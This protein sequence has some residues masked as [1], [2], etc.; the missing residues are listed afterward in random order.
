MRWEL[1]GIVLFF[2]LVFGLH[3]LFLLE[4]KPAPTLL[5]HIGASLLKFRGL[6]FRV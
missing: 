1:V 3:L 6:G 5:A 4:F 2:L